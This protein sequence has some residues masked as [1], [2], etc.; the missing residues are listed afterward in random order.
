MLKSNFIG[1]LTEVKIIQ[2]YF[3]FQVYFYI[4]LGLARAIVLVLV[5]MGM[6]I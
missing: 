4:A 3:Y 6:E 1:L 5:T 2:D